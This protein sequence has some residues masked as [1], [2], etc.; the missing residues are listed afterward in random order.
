MK[1][2]LTGGAGYIGSHCALELLAAGYEPV[3]LDN[4]SN[5]SAGALAALGTLAGRDLP[6]V[7]GDVRDGRA[8]VVFWTPGVR[9]ALDEADFARSRE[10]GATGVFERTVDGRP[11]DF[12]PNPDDPATF[13]DAQTQSVWNIFGSARSG[14][15]AGTQLT[16]V[17]HANHFWFAWA[18]FQP[19]TVVFGG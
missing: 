17:V 2:L 14:P 1:V 8:I 9:S 12:R 11:L 16:P 3:L 15:L 7:A 18:A 19:D 10:V 5:T 6:F 13:L 4:F